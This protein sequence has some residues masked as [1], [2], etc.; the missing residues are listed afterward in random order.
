MTVSEVTQRISML[1]L[2][3]EIIKVEGNRFIARSSNG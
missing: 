1:E 2:S 3:G